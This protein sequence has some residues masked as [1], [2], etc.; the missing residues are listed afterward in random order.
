MKSIYLDWG[1]G[2]TDPGASG[3]GIREKDWTRRITKYQYDRLK[4]LGAKVFMTRQNDVTFSPNART[5]EIKRIGADYCISNH[6]N[7]FSD[8]SANGV[9]TI[10]SV[11]ANRSM[12]NDL[13]DAIVKVSGLAKRRVFT[14]LHPQGGDYYFM[15]RQTGRSQTT[16]IE[17]GFLTNSKDAN[18]Y[19]N[20]ANFFKSAE[21]VIEVVCKYLG[22]KY[23]TVSQMKQEVKSDTKYDRVSVDVALQDLKL[24]PNEWKTREVSVE[25]TFILKHNIHSYNGLNFDS[26]EGLLNADTE[27]KFDLMAVPHRGKESE[28]YWLRGKI[29]GRTIYLPFAT[30]E[31]FQRGDYWGVFE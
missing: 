30:A 20:D 8:S 19:K 6:W 23:R 31:M 22:I 1:H 5:A 10:Y 15:H 27:V 9:E 11:Y 25:G 29:D 4:E 18:W 2:G 3:N 16:I 7:A 13:C 14:R 24:T 17:Y 26:H 12:A 28:H 21:A